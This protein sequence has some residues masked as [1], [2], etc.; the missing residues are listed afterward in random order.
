MA[1]EKTCTV[2][3]TGTLGPGLAVTSLVFTEVTAVDFEMK[4][5]VICITQAYKAQKNTY[6]DYSATATVTYVI[7]GNNAVITIS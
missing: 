1:A 6:F 2:T 5:N 3:I 4:R 7:T